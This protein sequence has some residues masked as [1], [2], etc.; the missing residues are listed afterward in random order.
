MLELS[1]SV[2]KYFVVFASSCS[3][4]AVNVLLIHIFA[5]HRLRLGLSLEGS[6]PRTLPSFVESCFLKESASVY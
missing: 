3:L 5:R 2:I 1:I 4:V 6:N